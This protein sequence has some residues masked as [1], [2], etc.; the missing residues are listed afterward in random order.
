MPIPNQAILA[1]LHRDVIAEEANVKEVVFADEPSE[2]GAE[3]LVVNP[4][5]V[6]KRLG[7]AMKDVLAA[8]EGGP[9]GHAFDDGAA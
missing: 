2:L 8:A 4:R 3:V 5:I 6:G 9:I 7:S 1:P